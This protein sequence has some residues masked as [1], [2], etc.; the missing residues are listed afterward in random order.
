[1]K[2]SS[3]DD[4]KKALG[5]K[6]WRNLSQENVTK[7]AAMMPDMD[8]EVALGIVKQLPEFKDFALGVV[9]AI[10]KAQEAAY[11]D[12]TKSMEHVYQAW[13]ETREILKGQLALE[14]L[15]WEQRKYI[16][17]QLMDAARE[18]SAKDSENK[19]WL[20]EIYE[21]IP[22]VGS[23]A[24]LATVVFVGGKIGLELPGSAG[25]RA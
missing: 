25:K 15:Q 7:F 12:N 16:L 24:V 18:V 13:Q 11:A 19:E 8:T 6:T 21:W 4:I 3:D 20:K 14:D 1:M 2:Y 5:I 23:V 10:Q 9:N 17:D 22:V